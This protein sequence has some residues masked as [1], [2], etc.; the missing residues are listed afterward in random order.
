MTIYNSRSLVV[1]CSLRQFPLCVP[2]PE[3]DL[4][5]LLWELLPPSL[6]AELLPCAVSLQRGADRRV[7]MET[8]SHNPEPCREPQ[9]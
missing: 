5:P 3:L 1:Q 7:D 8:P 2:A 6:R 4:Q 9:R